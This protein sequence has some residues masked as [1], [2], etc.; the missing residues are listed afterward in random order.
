[1][2]IDNICHL[3]QQHSQSLQRICFNCVQFFT[4]N[5]DLDNLMLEVE[6][7]EVLHIFSFSNRSPVVSEAL[8]LRLPKSVVHLHLSFQLSHCTCIQLIQQKPTHVAL[9]SFVILDSS[10]PYRNWPSQ[11]ESD[12]WQ[13]VGKI[14]QEVGVHFE[15]L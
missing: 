11:D 1:V 8:L 4:P 6:N 13:I 5:P 15:Y 9:A 14:V 12:K 7:L 10:W 2:D 3:F